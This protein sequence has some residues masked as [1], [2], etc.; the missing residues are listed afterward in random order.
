MPRAKTAS[1]HPPDKSTAY[2]RCGFLLVTVKQW[3]GSV[4]TLHMYA[5]WKNVNQQF[6]YAIIKRRVLRV[7]PV[8]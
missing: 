2:I 1:A 6:R 5:S 7:S 4:H 3:R 8:R